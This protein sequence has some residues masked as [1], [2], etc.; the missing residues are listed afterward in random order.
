MSKPYKWSTIGDPDKHTLRSGT[1]REL[2][3]AM[4]EKELREALELQKK[5]FEAYKRQTQLYTD[6]QE[7]LKNQYKTAEV[8]EKIQQSLREIKIEPNVSQEKE[9]SMNS[10]QPLFYG[11]PNENVDLWIFTTDQN[12]NNAHIKETNKLTTAASYFRDVAAQ[13][14]RK[15]LTDKPNITWNEVKILLLKHFTAPNYEDNLTKQLDNLKYSDLYKYIADFQFIINQLK[16][17][18]D[19]MQVYLFK[20]N[21]PTQLNN[22]V[23]YKRPKNLQEAIELA[24]SYYQSHSTEIQ[25]N[26]SQPNKWCNN[27]Q[28]NTHSTQECR[29]KINNQNGSRKQKYNLHQNDNKRQFHQNHY[30]NTQTPR[31]SN[32]FNQSKSQR[33]PHYNSN[34]NQQSTYQNKEIS[35]RIQ[36]HQQSNRITK[37]TYSIET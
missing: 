23:E 30:S 33:K 15:W 25:I 28:T 20:K 8:L 3:I 21:L 29:M 27:H 26:Y 31:T 37:P 19:R 13:I 4:T 1:V 12:L 32:W 24:Q 16:D 17:I 35:G 9:K 34:N 22:E 2:T 5:E 36:S 10:S 7:L 14:Y 6:Q 18:P 11:K